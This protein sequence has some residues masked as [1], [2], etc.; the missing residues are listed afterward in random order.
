M[1]INRFKSSG[2]VKWQTRD[3][4]TAVAFF[5]VATYCCD[6]LDRTVC[7]VLCAGCATAGEACGLE[8]L[9]RPGG[10][11]RSPAA[12]RIE[13]YLVLSLDLVPKPPDF[14]GLVWW[15]RI[16]AASD[17]HRHNNK[18]TA[19]VCGRCWVVNSLVLWKCVPL[20]D[21]GDAKLRGNLETPAVR[22]L[23]A[24]QRKEPPN[25]LFDGKTELHV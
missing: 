18:M 13:R 22:W 2:P 14:A 11:H 16:R 21:A 23:G 8:K 12:G 4:L 5:A 1:A 20:K 7:R 25:P 19:E 24:E 3:L 17:N 10:R 9:M 6:I 15:R